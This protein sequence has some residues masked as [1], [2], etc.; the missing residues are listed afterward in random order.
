[1][2]N[3]HEFVIGLVAFLTTSAPTFATGI[4]DLPLWDA[5]AAYDKDAAEFREIKDIKYITGAN[6]D[7][8]RHR[9]D[10]YVPKDLKDFPVVVLVH[11][12][13]WMVGDNRCCGLYP[14][15]GRYLASRGVGVVMPNYRLSPGVKHPE[16]IKDVARA[17]AWTNANIAKH[18]GDPAKLI[19]MGHSAGGHLV[20][21]LATDEQYLKAERLS[22]ADLR[23]VIAVSGVYTIPAGSFQVSLGGKGPE[24]FRFDAIA[25][26][27]GDNLPKF[28]KPLGSGVPIKIN[29]FSPA[30]GDDPKVRELAS[31]IRHVR[32][33][34]PPV[35]LFNADSDLPN[36]KAMAGDFHA[37]LKKAGNS[38][39]HVVILN[40]NHNTVMFRAIEPGDPVADR[41]LEFIG[42]IARKK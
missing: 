32:P 29:V 23:G 14:S 33:N 27:R 28:V 12:G 31:P 18:G 34:L 10:L 35:L 15:I 5:P 11:G 2:Q 4:T 26:L 8:V 1:V 25:S 36:L 30:F 7:P 17:V 42:Q 6:A 9:L 40:R 19:V 21:L 16:H 3:R 24:A 38:A 39:E 20:S 13:A 41:T 22:A 37:A